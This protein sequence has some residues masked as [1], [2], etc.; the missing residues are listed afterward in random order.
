MLGFRSLASLVVLVG[1]CPW[2]S[3]GDLTYRDL[4]YRDLASPEMALLIEV[5][6]PVQLIDNPLARDVWELVSQT[7]GFQRAL[8]ATEADRFRQV[9]RFI[10]KS[11]GVDWHTGLSRLT[12]GGILVVVE[13]S[14][15]PAEPAVTVVVTAADEQ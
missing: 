11:L 5:D 9:A 15:S 3:A 6:K 7:S 8:N 2:L 4:T 10:E 1:C 14:K 12:E 13:P